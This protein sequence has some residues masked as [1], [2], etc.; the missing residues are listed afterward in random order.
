MKGDD[1][2]AI[3]AKS[4][5]L[6]QVSEKLMQAAQQ[7]AQAN[8]QGQQSQGGNDDGVVDAEFEEVKDNK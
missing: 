8:T 3:E 6:I 2:D 5:A 7:Q 4:Q 1:K